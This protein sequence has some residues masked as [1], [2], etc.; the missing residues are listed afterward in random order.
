MRV[1]RKW[2]LL[3]LVTQITG[4]LSEGNSSIKCL[5]EYGI[6]WRT[7][8]MGLFLEVQDGV[9]RSHGS[10]S[11]FTAEVKGFGERANI[12]TEKSNKVVLE[13]EWAKLRQVVND[14]WEK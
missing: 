11:P 13:E 3:R 14:Q 9:L 5:G 7:V 6:D 4:L 8:T 1:V 2:V 12:G 10:D